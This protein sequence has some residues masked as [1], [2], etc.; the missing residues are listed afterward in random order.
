MLLLKSRLPRL[1]PLVISTDDPFT[2]L[3]QA[4]KD[5]SSL[6]VTPSS[7]PI[8]ATYGPDATL[9][10]EE[11]E[12]VLEDPDDEPVLGRRIFKSE[13][14]EFMGMCYLSSL[15]PFF[16]FFL[17]LAKFTLPFLSICQFLSFAKPFKGLG[18]AADVG[19]SA[20]ATPAAPITPIPVVSSALASTV[21]TASVFAVSSVPASIL[22]TAPIITGP[23][24]IFLPLFLSSSFFFFRKSCSSY[25]LCFFFSLIGT[26]LTASFQ[27]EVGS[28][29]ATILD[30]VQEAATFFARF[31]QPKV[32]DLGSADF[33]GSGPPYADFHGFRVPEDCVSHLVM[34]HCN[35]GDFM[36]E[37]RLG[38][39]AREHF[40]RM[41]G[42]VMNDIEHNF[43]DTVST[44]RIL[45]WRAA[46]QE[47]ISVG[48]AVEFILDHLREV[49]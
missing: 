35:C 8:S 39:S 30:P 40:L 24:E 49:A 41:L 14:E 9:S 47:F 3:S 34:V 22:P 12:D 16:S 38:R 44:E 20:A 32:N 23:S 4:V 36:Q 18:L 37:F 31:D 19:V 46:I 5:G 45:Q 48:I 15:L 7:I 25:A 11:S 6:V 27:F 10:S 13:E 2:T 17:F 33:W 28:S 42:S 21:F 26:L 29:S 43:V 1:R